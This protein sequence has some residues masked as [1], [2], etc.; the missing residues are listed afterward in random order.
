ME[1]SKIMGKCGAGMV[2]AWNGMKR[3]AGNTKQ[4]GK[5]AD[6]ETKIAKLTA[7]I[8]NLTVIKLDTGMQA[9]D[10]I[11]ERYN[12]I[13]EARKEIEAAE[14]GKNTAKAVCPHC[15]KHT[16]VGMKFCGHCGQEL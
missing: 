4:D 5:I 16:T 7:E 8:G 9:S 15:G 11:A 3:I 6:A 2:S 14:A 10:E 12:A 1:M 13:L